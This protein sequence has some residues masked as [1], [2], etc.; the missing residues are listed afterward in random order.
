M[1]QQGESDQYPIMLLLLNFAVCVVGC[2]VV[3]TA[4]TFL[5]KSKFVSV[6]FRFIGHAG[7]TLDLRH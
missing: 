7:N 4:Q 2:N 5:R 3:S 1:E 6:S